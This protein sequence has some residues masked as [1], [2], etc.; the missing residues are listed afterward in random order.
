LT[1][2]LTLL[3]DEDAFPDHCMPFPGNAHFPHGACPVFGLHQNRP[4]DGGKTGQG[5]QPGDHLP[6]ADAFCDRG[7]YR[8]PL[9]E[10]AERR[11]R[12]H[13]IHRFRYPMPGGNCCRKADSSPACTYR[14]RPLLLFQ[15]PLSGFY[16]AI[17]ALRLYS[18]R[19]RCFFMCAIAKLLLPAYSAG[20]PG[21]FLPGTT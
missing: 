9:V 7:L 19:S 16:T 21:I 3:P 6:D 5:A 18:G 8:F 12:K 15:T 13:I 10:G 2:G 4:P 20:T 1:P 11:G 14:T 17:P